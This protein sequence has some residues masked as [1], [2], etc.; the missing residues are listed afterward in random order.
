MSD[1]KVDQQTFTG[2][3]DIHRHYTHRAKEDN[4]KAT[5]ILMGKINDWIK[6][7]WNPRFCK[8]LAECNIKLVDF[9]YILMNTF[10]SANTKTGLRLITSGS[11]MQDE[12]R[13]EVD[14]KVSLSNPFAQCVGSF[15]TIVR[16]AQSKAA[17]MLTTHQALMSALLVTLS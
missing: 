3:I 7:N 2:M 14:I 5:K 15:F 1:A 9:R 17:L 11:P 4:A 8:A 6:I 16:V 13:R 10:Q 12:G